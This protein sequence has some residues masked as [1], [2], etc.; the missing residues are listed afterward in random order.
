MIMGERGTLA[1]HIHYKTLSI[2][3]VSWKP[4]PFQPP[5][6]ES[7]M[8]LCTSGNTTTSAVTA[9]TEKSSGDG[10]ETPSIAEGEHPV[11]GWPLVGNEA[12]NLYIGI[13]GIHSLIPY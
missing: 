12:I 6:N 10:V 3:K 2:Q 13:L 7:M 5:R 1:Y 11:A 9:I 8:T 4:L